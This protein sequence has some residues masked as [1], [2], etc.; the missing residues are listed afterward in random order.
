MTENKKPTPD[1]VGVD[2]CRGGWYAVKQDG[3]TGTIRAGVW[4]KFEELLS[5]APAPAIIAVDMPIGLAST[6]KRGCDVAARALLNWPRSASVFHTPVRQTLGSTSHMEACDRHRAA[7]TQGISRQA[8]NILPKIEEVDELLRRPSSNA[9]RVFE[10]H[11]EL[12]FMQLQIDQGGPPGGVMERKG[13]QGGYRVRKALLA[14]VFGPDLD[15]A[16]VARIPGE[17]GLDDILDAF[18]ALWSARRIA[19]G[20]ACKVPDREAIDVVGLPMAIRY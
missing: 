3:R 14:T 19:D 2:G 4:R 1:L 15:A 11:P 17:A 12:T 6:G 13:K 8:F 20:T 7:T 16:L 18:A 9:A 10:V 5:W